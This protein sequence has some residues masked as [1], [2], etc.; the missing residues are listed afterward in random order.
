MSEANSPRIKKLHEVRSS[1][2]D[3]M[4]LLSLHEVGA[5]GALVAGPATADELGQRL[6][7]IG[8][9]LKP[10]LEL[11]A[12]LGMLHHE[13]GRFWLY[14]GDEKFFDPGLDYGVGLPATTLQQFFTTKGSA[15]DILRGGATIQAAAAGGKSSVEKKS[16]FLRYMDAVTKEPAQELAA[17]IPA[18]NVRR[19]MDLGCGPG[20]YAYAALE[21]FPEAKAL[22]ADRPEAEPEI[23]AIAEERGLADRIEFRATDLTSDQLPSGQDIAIL[24]NVV[25]CLSA[26]TNAKLIARIAAALA[27]DGCLLI[28]DCAI[29]EDRSGP[30]EV[31]RFAISMVMFSEEGSIYSAEEAVAWCRSAGLSD[32]SIH[33]VESDDNYVVIARR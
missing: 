27:P 30:A 24:S 21:R 11:A 18:G 5:Y 10:F 31:L 16:E 7:L 2:D 17:L 20:T 33:S 15:P 26:K 22:L 8:S 9:R 4:V 19:I 3:A 25:H 23:Y 6:G 12:H 28:K 1:I 32:T 13:E 29:E 14:E